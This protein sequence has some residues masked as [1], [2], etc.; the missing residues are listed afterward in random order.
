MPET[1]FK[2][3]HSWVSA[4]EFPWLLQKAIKLLRLAVSLIGQAETSVCA[5]NA[6]DRNFQGGSLFASDGLKPL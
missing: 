1:M 2:E 3:Q 4:K 5:N 6:G